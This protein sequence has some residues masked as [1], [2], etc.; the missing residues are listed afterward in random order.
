MSHSSRPCRNVCPVLPS[1]HNHYS[2]ILQPIV[3]ELQFS[4]LYHC[5]NYDYM[6]KLLW[7]IPTDARLRLCSEF[8]TFFLQSRWFGDD[9]TQSIR[10]LNIL[11][12]CPLSACTRD[13]DGMTSLHHFC[14]RG[15][16]I[17]DHEILRRILEI[18]PDLPLVQNNLGESPLH[19]LVAQNYPDPNVIAAILKACPMACR[20]VIPCS[21]KLPLHLIF[22][23]S[24]LNSNASCFEAA[25]M[26]VR[27]FPEA[28]IKEVSEGE[29]A[30]SLCAN[31][32]WSP[33]ARAKEETPQVRYNISVLW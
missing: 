22:T 9:A 18:N 31:R 10:I 26:I 13:S 24:R 5:E 23:N 8:L 1:V 2:R 19:Q 21:G 15:K 29:A 3:G 27:G 32:K 16:G 6:V 25:K 11:K 12:L 33:F 28:A 14:M 30:C 17:C 4:L 20:Q 7:K